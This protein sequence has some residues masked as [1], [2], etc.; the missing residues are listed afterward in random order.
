MVRI[1]MADNFEIRKCL[2]SLSIKK[3]SHKSRNEKYDFAKMPR[4]L[5]GRLTNVTDLY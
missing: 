3:E 1:E 2:S 4:E 5:I